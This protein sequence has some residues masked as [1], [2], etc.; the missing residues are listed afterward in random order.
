MREGP[1]TVPPV[2]V[3]GGDDER[4]GEG[5][6]RPNAEQRRVEGEVDDVT[7]EPDDAELGELDPVMWAPQRLDCAVLE[8]RRLLRPERGKHRPRGYPI[9]QPASARGTSRALALRGR[10]EPRRR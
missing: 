3:R 6:V 5:P 2:V 7:G 9:R 8:H 10:R 4:D 1:V